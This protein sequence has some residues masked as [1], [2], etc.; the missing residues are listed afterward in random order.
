MNLVNAARMGISLM[1]LTTLNNGDTPATITR[2]AESARTDFGVPAA[3]CVFPEHVVWTKLELARLALPQVKVATVVN[4]P[5]GYTDVQRCVAE[6]QRAVAAGADEIDI[7]MPWRSLQQ[8]NTNLVEQMLIEVKNVC[9]SAPLKVI[10]ES[11]ELESE[12]LIRQASEIAIACGADFIKTST[13]KVAV[14]ATLTA[15]KVML[16]AIKDS[17]KNCGF[18]AAGGVRTAA[19]VQDYLQLAESIM[20]ADWVSPKT[21]R[22][23]ASSLL[24]NLVGT[25]EGSDPVATGK[26]SY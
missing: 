17:G 13:G 7:V 21:F 25:L 26:E 8:G 20:G 19:D 2:L 5:G 11:G 10:I 15:A 23:G 16:E 14:N 1:D 22:F 18:K 4:F 24:A 3:L 9:G 6:T 12:A